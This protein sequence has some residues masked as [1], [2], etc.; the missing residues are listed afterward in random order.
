[1]SVQNL[2]DEGLESVVEATPEER[3]ALA[4]D[5]KLPAIHALEGRFTLTGGPESVHVSGKVTARVEQVCVVT[6]EPFES[7]IEEEVDLD[8][9]S[10]DHLTP[11]EHLPSA[12]GH[13]GEHDF[14]P[15]DEIVGGAIDLGAITAEF[16]ALGLDPY[17]RKPGVAFEPAPESAAADSPFAA[18]S[19]L[20]KS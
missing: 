20:R 15:P 19:R 7:A 4:R 12:S 18:L 14:D 13:E 10:G 8:F 1:V 9:A 5:F 6:L 17:P 11:P 3:A 2:P 16:L